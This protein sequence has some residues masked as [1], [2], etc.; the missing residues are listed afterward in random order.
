LLTELAEETQ[1]YASLTST[2]DHLSDGN[3][4]GQH[5]LDILYLSPSIHLSKVERMLQRLGV[6]YQGLRKVMQRSTRK[7][8]VG[9]N[10]HAGAVSACRGMHGK[11]VPDIKQRNTLVISVN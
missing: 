2:R 8:T 11:M 9:Y 4:L 10:S 5:K 1:G 6:Q 7:F 3:D